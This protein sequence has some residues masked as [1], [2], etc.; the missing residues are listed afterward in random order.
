MKT[1][2]S[3]DMEGI[4]GVVDW[5]QIVKG[6]ES[7]DYD[8]FRALMVQDVNAAVEGALEAGA[9]TILVNDAHASMRNILITALHPEAELVTGTPKPLSMMEGLD[10]S[11]QAV[12]FIG[13]HARAGAPGVLNHTYSGTLMECR[14]NGQAVGETGLNAAVAGHFGV[15]VALVTGDDLVTAEA[16]DLLGPVRTVAVKQALGRY[17]ARCLHPDRTRDLIRIAAREALGR[18]DA[19][20]PYRPVLPLRVEID[21]RDSGQADAAMLLPGLDR[22]GGRTVAFTAPDLLRAYRMTRVVLRLGGS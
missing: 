6:K 11:F 10:G 1:Y 5:T 18:L 12:F 8:R 9:T 22:V 4:S 3:V 21:L 20:R 15:P 16:C 13:Y 7:E 14:F 2:I 17:A 19:V